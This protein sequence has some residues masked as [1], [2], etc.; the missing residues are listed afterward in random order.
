MTPVKVSDY[1]EQLKMNTVHKTNSGDPAIQVASYFLVEV[2]VL[3]LGFKQL[4]FVHGDGVLVGLLCSCIS[5]SVLLRFCV[6]IV[7]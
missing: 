5:L 7:H 1:E 6:H 4:H 3:H 2:H